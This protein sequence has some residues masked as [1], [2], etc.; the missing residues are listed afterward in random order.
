MY[1]T[2]RGSKTRIGIY[3][4]ANTAYQ[5]RDDMAVALYNDMVRISSEFFTVTPKKTPSSILA[6]LHDQMSNYAFTAGRTAS[7][8]A[9]KKLTGK[10]NGGQDDALITTMCCLSYGK[11]L[12][13]N[14]GRNALVR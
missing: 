3:K 5:Y 6:L 12:Y 13:V 9:K 11:L 2:E 1:K 10:I 4:G 8:D 7:V 14:P